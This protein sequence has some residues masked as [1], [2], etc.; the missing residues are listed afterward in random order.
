M[1][2]KAHYNVYSFHDRLK[3]QATEITNAQALLIVKINELKEKR[4]EAS[5][6]ERRH[7][8]EDHGAVHRGF[9]THR[10][11]QDPALRRSRPAVGHLCLGREC[12]DH[13][14]E[15]L[16]R[17]A[18]PKPWGTTASVE[19]LPGRPA[20]PGA[21]LMLFAVSPLPYGSALKTGHIS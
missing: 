8:P 2:H 20:R 10:H 19:S 3:Q 11:R 15:P 4:H 18:L 9:P 1:R 12:C 21:R 16:A 6:V 7:Q 17:G 5:P 13:F 14:S